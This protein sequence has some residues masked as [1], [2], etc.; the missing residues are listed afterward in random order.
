MG[1]RIAI[2]VEHSGIAC[3]KMIDRE[4][5]NIFTDDFIQDFIR[6]M[7]EI[8]NKH[9]PKV[10]ILQGLEDVFCGGAEKKGLLDLCDG[11]VV[12]KD[13]LLSER[14]LN[15]NFPV[16]AAI[17]GHAVGGGLVLALCCDIVIIARESRYGAV[18]MN[19]GFTP[20]M[21]CTT[22]LPYIMGPFIANEM[23]FTGKR[24][25]G[26]ELEEKGTN[27]NY[28]LPRKEVIPKARDIA[29]QISEKNVKSLYLLKYV[30]SA[31][32][33]KLLI[34]ARVQEDMM[35]RIS[36]GFPETKNTIEEFYAD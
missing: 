13:L 11:K 36:F 15:T 5:R 18:F 19:M 17:E 35:H 20:G 30:L 8:E 24:F 6:A 12:V 33:K 23:M 27:I 32:K 9:K 16:I 21:G 1:K 25:R 7:D 26:S 34:D 2:E 31:E 10:M 22:L 3:L 29:L 28:I 14:V 4:G